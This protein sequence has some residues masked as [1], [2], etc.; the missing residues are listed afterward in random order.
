[1]ARRRLSASD[2]GNLLDLK[3]AATYR[4]LNGTTDF[5][6]DELDTVC[7]WLGVGILD[8]FARARAVA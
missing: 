6:V 8:L 4:R 3:M 1:M 5:T 2:L 7:E